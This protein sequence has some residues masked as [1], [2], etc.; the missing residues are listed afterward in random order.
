M[1]SPAPRLG[2]GN[3]QYQYRIG[4]EGIDC[5]PSKKGPGILVDEK[6]DMTQQCALNPLIL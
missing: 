2:W 5:S 6:L 3:L 1:Q 4:D